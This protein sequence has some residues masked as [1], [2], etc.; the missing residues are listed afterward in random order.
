MKA[1]DAVTFKKMPALA[2][3]REIVTISSSGGYSPTMG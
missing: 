2:A 3:D 1:E